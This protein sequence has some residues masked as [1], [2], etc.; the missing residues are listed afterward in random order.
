MR[1]AALTV[2]VKS[3]KELDL[4]FNFIHDDGAKSLAK[5]VSSK[6]KFS[7]LDLS[8]NQIE[9]FGAKAVK[10]VARKKLKVPL[11]GNPSERVSPYKE[12]AVAVAPG[13]GG[14]ML[15]QI[16]SLVVAGW[17]R[18]STTAEPGGR[19]GQGHMN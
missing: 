9:I 17:P 15:P 14:L 4:C 19:R 8:H 12:P 13:P 7:R 5:A 3:L 10:A 1:L 6:G 2:K 16:R 18:R 11:E